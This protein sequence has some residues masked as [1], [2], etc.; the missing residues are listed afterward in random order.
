LHFP[1]FLNTNRKALKKIQYNIALRDKTEDQK[2]SPSKGKRNTSN[3]ENTIHRTRERIAPPIPSPTSGGSISKP[4]IVGV[5]LTY[6]FNLSLFKILPILSFNFKPK[7]NP[8]VINKKND[9]AKI[10][11]DAIEF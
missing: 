4:F 9:P 5:L 2:K 11:V 6:C 8:K 3:I 10:D 1:E 7:Y